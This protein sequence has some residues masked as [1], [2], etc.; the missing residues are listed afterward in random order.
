MAK[1]EPKDCI[2]GPPTCLP[3]VFADHTKKKV[4]TAEVVLF[5]K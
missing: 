4:K 1:V 5:V 3:G 2:E